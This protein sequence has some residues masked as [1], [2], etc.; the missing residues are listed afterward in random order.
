M[1]YAYFDSPAGSPLGRMRLTE[2]DGDLVA[3]DFDSFL[4]SA[5]AD[6]SVRILA[7]TQAWL[8]AYFAVR[9]LRDLPDKMPRLKPAG[10][11]FQQRVWSELAHIPWGECITYAELAQRLDTSPRA[12]GGA[13][14]ANP[15]PILIPCHRVV[16]ASGLGGYAGAS[17]L[18]QARK[19]WLLRHEG[20]AI[21]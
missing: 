12:V 17:E 2:E 5:L 11:N 10:T 14:R 8:A 16:A 1:N 4:S 21:A 18:G 7:Q 9:G 15:I 13:L 19:R 20:V 3:L 6:E